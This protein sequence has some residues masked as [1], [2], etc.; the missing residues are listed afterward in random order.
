MGLRSVF[1]YLLVFCLLLV[2]LR[3]YRHLPDSTL[4]PETVPQYFSSAQ[5]YVSQDVQ[6]LQP[7][8]TVVTSYLHPTSSDGI[9]DI[10]ADPLYLRYL[11]SFS[12]ILNPVIAFFDNRTIADAFQELRIGLDTQIIIVKSQHLQAYQLD[13]QMQR[14]FMKLN[15]SLG[16]RIACMTHFKYELVSRAVRDSLFRTR[17]FAWLDVSYYKDI[18]HSSSHAFKICLPINFIEDRVAFNAPFTRKPYLVDDI[19]KHSRAW[20]SSNLFIANRDTILAF[21]RDYHQALFRFLEEGLANTDQQVLFAM[22][23]EEY[24]RLFSTVRVNEY[25]ADPRVDNYH[26]LGIILREFWYRKL[27]TD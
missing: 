13:S 7:G 20:V 21:C 16:S 26:S 27:V 6:S 24:T 14:I 18:V 15:L 22:F 25:P 23:S 5:N 3:I 8:V 10:T 2:S 19:F 11:T 4:Q 12:Y 17:Y 9:Q 1:S